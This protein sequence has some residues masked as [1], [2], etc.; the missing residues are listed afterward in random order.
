[1]FYLWFI[2]SAICGGLVVFGLYLQLR[3]QAR[4][5]RGKEAKSPLDLAQEMEREEEAA[6]HRAEIQEQ[7]KK[8]AA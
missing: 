4:R 1:M 3:G 2:P 5:T 8:K 6:E 7:E